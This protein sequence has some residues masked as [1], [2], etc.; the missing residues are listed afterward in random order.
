MADDNRPIKILVVAPVVGE[1][2]EC[3]DQLTAAFSGVPP[4]NAIAAVLI[5]DSKDPDRCAERARALIPLAQSHGAAA[6]VSRHSDIAVET[7]ADGWHSDTDVGDLKRGRSN[8]GS[9]LIVGAGNLASRHAAMDAAEAGCDY[10]FFGRPQGDGFPDP[11]PK[12]IELATWWSELMTVPAVMMAGNALSGL[13]Q[14]LDTGAEFIAVNRLIWDDPSG[15]GPAM[16]AL[17]E[18]IRRW[19][20]SKPSNSQDQTT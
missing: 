8:L 17:H 2:A 7:G 15:P 1:P 6:L 16:K 14:A 20:R 4:G 11:H 12:M 10:V 13:P 9:G 3:A 5:A 19:Q 18:E